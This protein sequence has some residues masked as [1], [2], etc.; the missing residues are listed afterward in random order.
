MAEYPKSKST[1][2]HCELLEH[3]SNS[4]HR[5]Q[6]ALF[7]VIACCTYC[8]NNPKTFG[9]PT[10]GDDRWLRPYV[11]AYGLANAAMSFSAYIAVKLAPISDVI[12]FCYTSLIFTIAFSAC[13]LRLLSLLPYTYSYRMSRQVDY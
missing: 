2:P 8:N 1:K 10:H 12:V 4:I 7:T 9:L 11:V 5:P 13:I 6:T 3:I